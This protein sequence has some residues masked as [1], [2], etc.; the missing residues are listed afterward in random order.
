M[1][2]EPDSGTFDVW[3]DL[4]M[5]GDDVREDARSQAA[6][7]DMVRAISA[8]PG[9]IGYIALGYLSASTKPLRVDGVMGSLYSVRD[10]SYPLSRPLFMF[11]RGWPGGTL[12]E[13]I[14]FALDPGRGQRIVLSSGFVPVHAETR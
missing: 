3:R 13:F 9:G 8:E 7:T 14:N 10:G 2:R 11:T 1:T 4:V 12:L 6:H 5:G